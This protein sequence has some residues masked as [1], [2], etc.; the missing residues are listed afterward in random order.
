[1][2][3]FCAVFDVVVLALV[4]ILIQFHQF[5]VLYSC[6]LRSLQERHDPSRHDG[7]DLCQIRLERVH[8]FVAHEN[9]LVK[10]HNVIVDALALPR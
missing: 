5:F 10:L 2:N 9:L 8:N 6:S 3:L 7:L 4:Q 1:M